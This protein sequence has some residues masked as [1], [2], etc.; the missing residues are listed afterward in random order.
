MV[1][2]VQH[3]L[4][5]KPLTVARINPERR[6]TMLLYLKTLSDALNTV[7]FGFCLQKLT[8]FSAEAD[9]ASNS[10]S[11]GSSSSVKY[12]SS[13]VV[14]AETRSFGSASNSLHVIF[15]TSMVDV[16]AWSAGTNR[17]Q[18]MAA[19]ASWHLIGV[20]GIP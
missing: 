15:P 5:R 9:I 13:Q 2:L 1:L 3:D 19:P 17:T 7:A 4:S 14:T 12:P 10:I 16:C 11:L 6:V 18:A 8:S 20:I